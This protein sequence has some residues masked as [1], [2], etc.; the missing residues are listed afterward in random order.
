MRDPEWSGVQKDAAQHD[1]AK[2]D[3]ILFDGANPYKSSTLQAR[4]GISSSSKTRDSDKLGPS[5]VRNSIPGSPPPSARDQLRTS[6]AGNNGVLTCSS[7]REGCP[8][9]RSTELNPVSVVHDSPSPACPIQ[10]LN[11]SSCR[12]P[13]TYHREP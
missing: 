3:Q 6:N 9:G 10:T 7:P 1:I 2:A 5:S 8:P 4:S 11:P 13:G 12:L